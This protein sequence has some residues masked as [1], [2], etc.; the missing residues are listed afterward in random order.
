MVILRIK[1][2]ALLG[3]VTDSGNGLV[4]GFHQDSQSDFHP[5]LFRL[6]LQ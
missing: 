1:R 2:V 4:M 5:H 3:V 6:L